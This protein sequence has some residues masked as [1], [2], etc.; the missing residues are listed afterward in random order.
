TQELEH[1][2][3]RDPDKDGKLKVLQK[4]EIKEL[5]GRSPDFADMLMMRMFF[6]LQ[7]A[8]KVHVAK[9][10]KPSFAKKAA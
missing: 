1:V 2:K 3:R 10:W 6:E 4:D 7:E 9:Q 5:L 8:D